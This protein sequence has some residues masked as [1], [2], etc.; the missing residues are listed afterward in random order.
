MEFKRPTG[1]VMPLQEYN[2]KMLRDMNF[3]V[4]VVRSREQF[5]SILAG[6]QLSHG[7]LTTT[8]DEQ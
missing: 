6:S 8:N 3:Q 1:K 5:L 4:E 2:H 7:S